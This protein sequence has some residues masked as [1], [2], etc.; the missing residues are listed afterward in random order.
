MQRTRFK[1][2]APCNLPFYTPPDS[3]TR[4]A[5]LKPRPFK[6]TAVERIFPQP[7]KLRSK[8]ALIRRPEGRRFHRSFASGSVM[9][10]PGQADCCAL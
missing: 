8:E 7:V 3:Q 6:E 9:N 1:P 5:R 2:S 4:A 10:H